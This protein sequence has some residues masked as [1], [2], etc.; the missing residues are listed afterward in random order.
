VVADD[1]VFLAV[2]LYSL[3]ESSTV[4]SCFPGLRENGADFIKAIS[5]SNDFSPDRVRILGT[6]ASAFT[7]FARKV[8]DDWSILEY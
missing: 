6:R 1:S 7:D 2:L 8:I 5:T 3:S 4:I